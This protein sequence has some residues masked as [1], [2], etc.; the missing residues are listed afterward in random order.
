LPAIVYNIPG[1]TAVDI[2]AETF[3]RLA[4]HPEIVGVKEASGS[5]GKLMDIAEAVQ[6]KM[7]IYAGDDNATFVTMSVGGAGVITASA[8]AIPKEMVKIV[9]ATARG[10]FKAGCQAQVDAL[11]AIR[12]LFVETN[13]A[14]VKAALMM[15]GKIPSD[16]VR[17]PLVPVKAET[18]ELL[19][20]T[21]VNRA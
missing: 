14:P 18:R 9:D 20:K 19:R 2:G 7:K 12:S 17:L 15:M 13:P 5:I 6:G 4:K 16:R 11:E 3:A 21:I 8:N 10:D 1:R